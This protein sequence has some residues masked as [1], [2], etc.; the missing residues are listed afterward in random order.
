MRRVLRVA[1]IVIGVLVVLL[2]IAPFVISVDR[3]RPIIEEKAS[4]VLGRSVHL[5]RLSLS[6]LSGSLSAEDL[7][8]GDD[9]AFSESP[10]LTA[11]SLKVGVE[12][13]PLLFSRTLNVTGVTIDTPEVT[14]LRT[15]AGQWNFASLASLGGKSDAAQT[16]AAPDF[17]IKKIELVNG[18]IVVARKGS[19]KRSTYDHVAITAS[20]VSM[21]A[22]FPVTLSADL[23]SGGTLTLDGRAGPVDRRD[24]SL[25]PLS[26]KL[27]VKSLN[28]AMTGFLDGS[29]GLGG[30]VDLDSAFESRSGEATVKGT[31]T[32]SKALLVAG[33]SPA[34][35]PVTV[36]FDTIYNLKSSVGV[37]NPSVLAIGKAAAR[38]NGTYNTAAETTLVQ[39]RMRASDMPASDLQ[40]FLPALNLTL[41]KGSSLQAGSLS[42][43]LQIAGPVNR[44]VV[45][46]N[47]G[48]LGAK[49][50]GFDLGARMST[51]AALAGYKTGKDLD[52]EKLTTDLR[53]APNGI[54]AANFVLVVPGL[55]NLTG[56]GT[57][58]AKNGL[59]FKMVAALTTAAGATAAGGSAAAPASS[60][61]A[62]S[63]AGPT[64]PASGGLAGL[65]GKLGFGDK[66][67]S[68][69]DKAG[70]V[71]NL[72]RKYA[73]ATCT[74]G[75]T[76]PFQVKGTTADP[77]FVP[78]VGGL[79]AS[80]LKTK[81]GCL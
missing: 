24:A 76:V 63:A 4:A 25:S 22:A 36:T 19:E 48:M 6:L 61:A 75:M 11:K 12:I 80:L 44:L 39:V 79:A 27:I 56:A 40:A 38:L 20:D 23:P 65:A 49:L 29:A 5:G 43:D 54:E 28:L 60:P 9:P 16:Q 74:G 15:P 66:L 26:A 31:A 45:T 42:T 69:G 47:V 50:A 70:T 46:G 37:L 13:L 18:R 53:V 59:D 1:L 57:V 21:A 68:L 64:Q 17:S 73:G 58:D 33:G 3:F 67:A 41:P 34:G 52:I 51:V 14:L 30:I 2:A 77:K 10:F 35:V 7:A 71:G 32:L 78:D 81:L 55:G 72:A 8:I 62:G